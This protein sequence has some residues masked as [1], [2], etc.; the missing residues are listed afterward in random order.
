MSDRGKMG[1]TGVRQ[2]RDMSDRG[3]MGETGVRQG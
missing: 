1:E 3:K 2:G